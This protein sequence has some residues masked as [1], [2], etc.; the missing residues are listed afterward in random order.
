MVKIVD[1]LY[2]GSDEDVSK[3]KAEGMAR[4]ACCKDGPD[5]HRAMLGY[6]TLGAPKGK[7]YL[8]ARKG[9]WMA[10][11][12]IDVDN[13]EFIKDAT[14]DAGIAFIK[15]QID[16][17]HKVLVHCNAGMSRGPSVALMYLRSAGQ[18]PNMTFS[19][20]VHMFKTLYPKYSPALGIEHHVSSRWGGV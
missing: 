13:P 9:K 14:L 5:G 7:D 12:L 16:S 1:G 20:G 11:N 15:E 4:L 6:T 3:A 19:R 18:L 2:V 17:G 10:L 8:F